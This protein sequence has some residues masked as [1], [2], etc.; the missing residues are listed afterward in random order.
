MTKNRWLNA[1]LALPVTSSTLSVRF[2]TDGGSPSN[3]GQIS[4]FITN[5][6][7]GTFST[8]FGGHK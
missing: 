2:I 7:L 1:L 6:T 4:A 8:E 3:S 5:S